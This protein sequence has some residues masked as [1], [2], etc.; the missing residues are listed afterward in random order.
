MFG[1]SPTVQSSHQCLPFLDVLQFLFALLLLLLLHL[2][3]FSLV[4]TLGAAWYCAS[5]SVTGSILTS[6][7]ASSSFL[8][9]LS[10]LIMPQQCR[11]SLQFILESDVGFSWS[12]YPLPISIWKKKWAELYKNILWV[13]CLSQMRPLTLS[14]CYLSI[15]LLRWLNQSFLA[16]ANPYLIQTHTQA[17]THTNTH[18]HAQGGTASFLSN[19]G[20][21]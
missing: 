6:S 5:T 3:A 16:F 11:N 17:D 21:Q 14:S 10:L 7:L 20:C 1:W 4:T 8:S 19:T 9:T 13:A 12:D 18:A 2:R 15:N